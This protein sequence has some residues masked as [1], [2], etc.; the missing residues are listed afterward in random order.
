MR[1]S[2]F[3]VLSSLCCICL[4]GLVGCAVKSARAP[5]TNVASTE[6][7]HLAGLGDNAVDIGSEIKE[8]VVP[9]TLASV[10][11]HAALHFQFGVVSKG[12]CPS[13][14]IPTTIAINSKSVASLDF[15]TFARGA[16]KDISVPIPNGILKVGENLLH[17]RTG[18]CQYDIDVMRLNSL[19]L[20]Q[21]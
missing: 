5:E 6:N 1:S 19:T 9:F 11:D 15:R 2:I 13:T 18:S 4:L 20:E 8:Y 14:Y 16:E 3:N 21:K 12:R 17:I 7:A 10:P